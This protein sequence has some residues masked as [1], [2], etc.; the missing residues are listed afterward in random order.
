MRGPLLSVIM[1]V[2]GREDLLEEALRALVSSDLPREAWELIVV[3]DGSCNECATVAARVAD[4]VVRLPGAVRGPAYARNRGVEV[5]RGELLLFLDGDVAVHTDTIRRLVEVLERDGSVAGVFGSADDAPAAGGLVSR[6]WNLL[7][8]Y[9]CRTHPGEAW[10]FDASCGAIRRSSL[11]AVNGFDEWH[12][13]APEIEDLELG[14]RLREAGHR[15]VLHDDIL[16]THLK[17]WSFT[18]LFRDAWRRGLMLGRLLDYAR[19]VA[20]A[21]SDVLHTLASARSIAACVSS[22]AVFLTAHRVGFSWLA[23]AGIALL[24]SI[25]VN[26]GVH[27]FLLRRGGVL[28]SLAAAPIHLTAQCISATALLSGWLLRHVIGEPTPDP[29]IQAFAEVGVKTWP[30]IPMKNG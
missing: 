27:V 24:V 29:A 4:T 17:E 9:G 22:L 2:D 20:L 6:Y 11:L 14:L 1:P 7:R 19:S 28:F 8:A 18:A 12:F 26:F 25:I 30:P 5:A 21:R 13:Q 16:V 15:L 10:T 3:D 23:A